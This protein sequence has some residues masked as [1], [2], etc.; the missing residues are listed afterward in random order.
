MKNEVERR[1]KY[2]TR[3]KD[4]F[5]LVWLRGVHP[6]AKSSSA[7]CITLKSQVIKIYQKAPRCAS[8]LK[9]K[10]CSVLSTAESSSVV[11]I[12]PQSQALWCASHRGV[13][14]EIFVSLWLLLKG[15]SGEILLGVNT[16]TVSWKKR[17]EENFF[18]LLSLKFWLWGVMHTAESKFSNFVICDLVKLKPNSKILYPVYQGPRWVRIMNK[19]KVENLVTHSL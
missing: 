13:K 5:E 12:A 4:I 14:I 3:R 18:D 8:H 11:C 2:K 7:V 6:S 16:S 19:M 1:Y 15:Q 9:V 10:L 17:F